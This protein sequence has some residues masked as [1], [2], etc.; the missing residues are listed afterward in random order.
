MSGH[1]KKLAPEWEKAAKV[2][3]ESDPP[4]TLV[5]VEATEEGNK[6][7][8]TKYGVGGFPT[9]K[10]RNNKAISPPLLMWPG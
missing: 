8:A 4:V 7:L 5:K 10:V 1:C 6:E 2:L 9:I 3:K